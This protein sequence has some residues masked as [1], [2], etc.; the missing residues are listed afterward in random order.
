MNAHK[1]L[2]TEDWLTLA[3]ETL[4]KQGI[5]KVNVEHLARELGVTKGSFYW[6]FKNREAL[7]TEMLDYWSVEL[8]TDVIDRSSQDTHD[9]K[10]S[11]FKLM[12]IITDENAGRYETAIRAWATHDEMARTRLQKIDK[13]RLKYVTNLFHKM[14][15]EKDDAG[16]RARLVLYYQ[17]AEH[18]ILLNDSKAKRNKLLKQ[19]FELLTKR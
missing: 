3:L 8:T 18:A 5:H 11:L 13:Q 15:F 12:S 16:L 1:K 6:H 19:R 7:L 9:A 10:E 4:D 17:V 2:T 14:N